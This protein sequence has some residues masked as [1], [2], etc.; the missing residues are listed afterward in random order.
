MIDTSIRP[1]TQTIQMQMGMIGDCHDY[2]KN[3]MILETIGMNA[4]ASPSHT[5]SFVLLVMP[6]MRDHTPM[7]NYEHEN[8]VEGMIQYEDSSQV[9]Y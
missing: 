2:T 6:K 8:K 9:E 4:I 5:P 3:G 1:Y 7:P